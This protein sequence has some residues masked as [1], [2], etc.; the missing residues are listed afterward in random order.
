MPPVSY[1][2]F[3]W[4][5]LMTVLVIAHLALL[6]FTWPAVTLCEPDCKVEWAI[7][8][9]NGIGFWIVLG[10]SIV[11]LVRVFRFSKDV[12]ASS[13]TTIRV[14][15]AYLFHRLGQ[16]GYGE[17]FGP[18]MVVS[19]LLFALSLIFWIGTQL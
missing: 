8:I 3:G 12:P 2:R 17:P 10:V 19:I 15:V 4:P 1:L 16:A 5:F 6:L 11:Y 9:Q 13:L 7:L 14:R 18:L